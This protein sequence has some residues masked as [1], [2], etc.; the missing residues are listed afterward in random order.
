MKAIIPDFQT[1]SAVPLYLQLYNYVKAAILDGSILP[2]ER[3]PSLRSLSKS[4]GLS[5]TTIEL[6]YNQLL[7]EGYIYSKPQSGYYV[8][9]IS[10]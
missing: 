6:A 5:I 2:S 1:R 8:N 3:L 7:V 9:R 10:S 4:L